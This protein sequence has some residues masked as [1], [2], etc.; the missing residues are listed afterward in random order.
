MHLK[1]C[2][3]H[4]SMGSAAWDQPEPRT[5][6]VWDGYAVKF[7]CYDCCTP[8]NVIKLSNKKIK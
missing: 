2:P 5:V 7:S 3:V 8:I 6:R 4:K 1:L